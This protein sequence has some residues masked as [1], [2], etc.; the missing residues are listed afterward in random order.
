[1]ALLPFLAF[2]PALAAQRPEIKLRS[3]VDS[4]LLVG[5]L[6][7]ELDDCDDLIEAS[8]RTFEAIDG[9]PLP[10]RR[11]AG[12]AVLVVNTASECGFT[13]QYKD[14]E[15]LW[16]RYRD[17]EFVV[18]GVPCN[19]FGGQEPG[20]GFAIPHEFRP[21]RQLIDVGHIHRN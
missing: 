9:S 1:M 20:D 7:S 15:A 17:R 4:E 21:S 11:F 10:L 19:D 2:G 12:K 8:R 16:R 6:R 3:E 18:L 13:P 5:L 14:L